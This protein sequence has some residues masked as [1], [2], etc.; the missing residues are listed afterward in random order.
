MKPKRIQRQRTRGWRMPEGAVYVGRPTIWGNPYDVKRYGLRLCMDLFRETATGCWNPT[1]APGPVAGN[2]LAYDAH[3][4][5][6]K[7]IGHHPV[8][9]IRALL[10]GKDLACWCP[11]DH[12]CHADVLLE[13]A[14]AQEATPCA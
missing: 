2:N 6:L 12:P 1:L 7:R 11:L 8:E 4:V 9:L 3:C 13:I 10:C 5:W 14:N